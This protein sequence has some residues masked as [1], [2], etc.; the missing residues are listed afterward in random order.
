VL[1]LITSKLLKRDPEDIK[2]AEIS[3]KK[4]WENTRKKQEDRD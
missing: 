3:M 2:S 4:G 1:V